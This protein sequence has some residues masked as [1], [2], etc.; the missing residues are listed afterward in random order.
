LGTPDLAL[1]LLLDYWA[2][3]PA[4]WLRTLALARRLAPEPETLVDAAADVWERGLNEPLIYQRSLMDLARRAGDRA[5]A[6]T[7]WSRLDD[8]SRT[9]EALLFP[10]VQML[11]AQGQ[12]AEA[13]AVWEQALGPPPGL[14]NGSFDEPL[15][16]LGPEFSPG[17][18]TPGWRYRPAGDGFR[19]TLDPSTDKAAPRTL[20]IAFLGTHNVNFSHLSQVIR[21][22]PGQSYRLTGYW[23]GDSITTRSGIFIEIYTIDSRPV[24]Q[25]RTPPRRGSW[26][27][28]PFVLDIQVP[29]DALLVGVRVLR[30]ATKALD[31]LLSGT[32]RLD[33]LE[34]QP[35][36]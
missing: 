25:A 31:N 27:R 30:T 1:A 28:E 24:V 13:D 12:H 33:T 20:N 26:D 14:A 36:P 3:A 11:A 19:I 8:E 16:P 9:Q 17:W 21:V 2:T 34:L 29:E 4:D 18:A 32:V 15:V 10:Y 5:L 23:S 6:Q 7:L 35:L 22:H